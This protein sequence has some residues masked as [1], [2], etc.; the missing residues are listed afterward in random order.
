MHSP[1]SAFPATNL[2]S[3]P[4]SF[5]TSPKTSPR[6]SPKGTTALNGSPSEK[7]EK[8][9]SHLTSTDLQFSTNQNNISNDDDIQL[10]KSYLKKRI[11]SFSNNN[12]RDD[13]SLVETK[14]EPLQDSQINMKQINENQNNEKQIN[15]EQI[16][17]PKLN[18]NDD[19]TFTPNRKNPSLDLSSSELRESELYDSPQIKSNQKTSTRN[20][21]TRKNDNRQNTE[22]SF[23]SRSKHSAAYLTAMKP[24]DSNKKHFHE[25]HPIGSNIEIDTNSEESQEMS[26][27]QSTIKP[28][29]ENP[30]TEHKKSPQEELEEI[31][32][33]Y[34]DTQ[35]KLDELQ[36]KAQNADVDK[37]FE[38]ITRELSDS[39]SGTNDEIFAF[40][41]DN[42]T[43]TDKILDEFQNIEV[44][45]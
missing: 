19:L 39:Q 1:T 15:D 6:T 22:V 21:S 43:D 37:Q 8:K 2:S 41:D 5:R 26:N 34:L 45:E 32:R 36:K 42:D 40:S 25:A 3:L 13:G 23:D 20:S 4:S 16:P 12:D 27:S 18:P 17:K 24:I 11:E 9:W 10:T 44:D 31:Q 33:L 14:I 35:K 38:K 29:Q 7:F 30:N 28:N